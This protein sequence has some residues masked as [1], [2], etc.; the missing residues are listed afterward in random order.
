MKKS[1]KLLEE[2]EQMIEEAPEQPDAAPAPQ[3]EPEALSRKRRQALVYYFAGLL[4]IAFLAVLISMLVQQRR[5][6]NTISDITAGRN[7]AI[8]KAE[9]LQDENR[10]LS[11][12]ISELEKELTAAKEEGDAQKSAREALEQELADSQKALENEQ[13]AAAKEKDRMKAYEYLLEARAAM[14]NKNSAEFQSA[15]KALE[16]LKDLLGEQG[17]TLYRTL[18]TLLPIES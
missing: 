14:E 6:A 2:V 18:E 9:Q 16:S 3:K 15:M 8:A 7:N 17:T 1:K 11:D 4:V 5:N 13:K 12:R 10:T